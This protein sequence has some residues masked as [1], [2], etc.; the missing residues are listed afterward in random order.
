MSKPA[1]PLFSK[2]HFYATA[3]YACSYLPN[4]TARSQ[5]AAPVYLID[6]EAYATLLKR[7]FRRSGLFSYR[8]YCEHCSACISVRI[9][10]A[11]FRPSRSQRRNGAT[12]RHLKIR[13]RHLEFDAEHYALYRDYQRRRHQGGAMDEDDKN[14]YI[15]FLL[16]SPVDSRLIEFRD[17][18]NTLR[19]V[20]LIDL[21]ADGLSSVYTF[22]DTEYAGGLGIYGILWQVELARR[23]NLPFV[24]LGYWIEHSPKMAYKRD[25]QPLE[26][27]IQ[28]QWRA[29][30]EI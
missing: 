5:V 28:G 29:S 10:T 22:Y 17:A 20:S 14:Q 3:P 26:Y 23:H 13:L 27:L 19:M 18:Q 24:Y 2:L 1:E 16:K 12:H 15:Q 11:E 30:P 9:R 8:P 25:F 21:L 6:S 7:G 4:R